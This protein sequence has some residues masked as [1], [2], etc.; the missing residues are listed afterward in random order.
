MSNVSNTTMLSFGVRGVG[1][2]NLV[3]AILMNP[4]STAVLMMVVTVTWIIAA[5]R[6]Y[7]SAE[8]T[9]LSAL[10]SRSIR[11]AGAAASRETIAQVRTCS[12][13]RG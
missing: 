10:G 8:A 12:N 4:V 2:R 3:L 1:P 13:R 5:A 11:F 7:A 9:R 6:R